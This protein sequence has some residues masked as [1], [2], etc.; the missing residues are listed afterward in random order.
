[1]AGS[2]PAAAALMAKNLSVK[3]GVN[4]SSLGRWLQVPAASAH[5]TQSAKMH[6]G[7]HFQG[8]QHR[9]QAATR[10][11]GFASSSS[12]HPAPKSWAT[13][14]ELGMYGA[15]AVVGMIGLSYASVP[16]YKIFCSATG[17]GGAVAGAV[18]VEEKLKR[19]LE[20]PNLELEKAAAQ[21]EITV[22]FNTDVADNM[23]WTFVPTQ[24][25]VRVIPGQSTLAFFTAHNKS[26]QAV[27]GY[28][29][30]SVAPD[31]AAQYFNKIQCFCF[32]E[33]R[34]RPGEVVDM[35]VFFYIEPD[36]AA[37]WNCRNV[38][39]LTLSYVFHM[40]ED[41]DED[42]EDDGVPGSGIKLHGHG[43]LPQAEP[44]VPIRVKIQ[45]PGEQQ[46]GLQALLNKPAQ[47][48]QPARPAAAA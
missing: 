43:V 25:C 31:K 26:D 7:V 38:Q 2:T 12:S 39:D 22:W 34:L 45:S 8:S 48:Q 4:P 41:G 35:P 46:P 29:V 16:L 3:S 10:L 15:A 21:R 17:Y 1:M 6:R 5:H 36:F 18:S 11:R 19:R 13:A 14:A 32:E 42:F 27:T 23:P 20:N 24:E 33:Q 28:S 30:Y 44:P 37:D 47:Q 40:V 9:L